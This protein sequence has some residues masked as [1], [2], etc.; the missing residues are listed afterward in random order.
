M[1]FE[2]M[3]TSQNFASHKTPDRLAEHFIAILI[4]PSRVKSDVKLID[5]YKVCERLRTQVC[6]ENLVKILY[7]D[8]IQSC[9]VS[10][11]VT[12]RMVVRKFKF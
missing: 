7:S 1:L 9:V 11:G 2:T 12:L 5:N 3:E 8:V 10:L 6:C 4:Y